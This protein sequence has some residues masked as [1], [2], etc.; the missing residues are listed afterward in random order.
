MAGSSWVGLPT[1]SVELVNQIDRPGVLQA[2]TAKQ[3]LDMGPV[4]LVGGRE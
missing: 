2:V 3:P 1:L 4:L